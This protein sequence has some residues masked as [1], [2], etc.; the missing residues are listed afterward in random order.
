MIRTR[1]ARGWNEGIAQLCAI[2][3][4]LRTSWED[5]VRIVRV[6]WYYTLMWITGMGRMDWGEDQCTVLHGRM[7]SARR[8]VFLHSPEVYTV[9]HLLSSM[10]Y[11]SL[12][13]A[14]AICCCL[15]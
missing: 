4:H 9:T 12:R 13:N 3:P 2:R 8:I 15:T 11:P 10:T 1:F 7:C 14:P 6:D 5:T